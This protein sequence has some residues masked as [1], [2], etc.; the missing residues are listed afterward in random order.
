[1]KILSEIRVTFSG[2]ISF[3]ISISSIITG[4]IFTLIVTRRLTPD[5]FGTWT[6]LGGLITYV[7]IIESI[8]SIWTTRDIARGRDPG[9]TA[10][11]FSGIFSM[12]GIGL[13]LLIAIFV[14]AQSSID[15]QPFLIATF[16]VPCMFLVRTLN[17][18]NYGHK[19]HAISF[20]LLGFEIVKIPI[21]LV[22]V[23]FLDLGISGAIITT[24]M[25][26]MVNIFILLRFSIE[27]IK[28]K[29]KISYLKKWLKLSW[30]SVYP[31]LS[32]FVLSLDVSIYSV[33]TGSVTGLAYIGVA[34]TIS[35]IV[36]QSGKISAGLYPKLLEGEK[37]EIIENNFTLMFYF[38]IPLTAFAIT[39]ARPGLF[40]LNP[41]YEIAIVVVW[42]MSIRVFIDAIGGIYSTV[43]TGLEKVDIEKKST[44]RDYFKSKLFI[45]PTIRL[46]QFSSYVGILV[47]IFYL[48]LGNSNLEL[49]IYW[50]MI[51]LICQIF[52]TSTLGLI[53]RKKMTLHF[54]YKALTKYTISSIFI[55]GI[56]YLL[57]ERFLI[58]EESIFVFIPNLIPFLVLVFSG[59]LG[60][61][62]MIDENTRKLF[63]KII[64]EISNKI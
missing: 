41:V 8:I 32:N 39:F 44:I 27:K 21:G 45:V 6:L 54:D 35:Q 15:L 57:M 14:A 64:K 3:I 13:Y 50:S 31:G 42:I 10:F 30:I 17:S 36:G 52:F 1:M 7:V 37:K 26:Y 34:N 22:L 38:A 25:A 58:Y 53:V 18:I 46:I 12:F 56:S 48:F 40:V 24:I 43:L 23:Y 63:K 47:I 29:I 16:L 55:F 59:Y 4:L 20:G 28:G 51:S 61:T 9:K 5:E 49:V 2:L 62:Y 33:I 19:P 60:I 11:F